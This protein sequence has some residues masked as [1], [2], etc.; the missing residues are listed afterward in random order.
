M[1]VD[2][3]LSIHFGN[4][5]LV[6][7]INLVLI[8]D[9]VF[10]QN[11]CKHSCFFQFKLLRF[12]TTSFQI[13]VKVLRFWDKRCVNKFYFQNRFLKAQFVFHAFRLY[14][15]IYRYKLALEAFSTIIEIIAAF[16]KLVLHPSLIKDFLD[17]KESGK[18]ISFLKIINFCSTVSSLIGTNFQSR[19]WIW[20]A[21]KMFVFFSKLC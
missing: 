17:A 13:R 7:S 2:E 12:S 16:Q 10:V 14:A 4:L 9:V 1:T 3:I 6:L 11:F 15:N 5:L 20:F 19:F 21:Y 8:V 18:K